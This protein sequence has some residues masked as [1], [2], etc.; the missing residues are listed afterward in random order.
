MIPL[1][2]D[3]TKLKSIREFAEA[4]PFSLSDLY[5]IMEGKVPCA[6]ER[7]GHVCYLD[8]GFKVVFSIEEH[9]HKDTGTVWLRHMSVSLKESTGTRVPSIQAI[10]LLCNALGFEPLE[11]C[12]VRLE[13]ETSPQYVEVFG[14]KQ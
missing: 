13:K 14:A 8:F 1:I 12:M 2:L 9:P 6:G 3:G 11:K 7:E 10:E 5:L 4:N